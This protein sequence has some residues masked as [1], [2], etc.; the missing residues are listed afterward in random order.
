VLIS[1]LFQLVGVINFRK[2]YSPPLVR[3]LNPTGSD[4]EH[5]I[6]TGWWCKAAVMMDYHR[7]LVRQSDGD[8]YQPAH[9]YEP[10]VILSSPTIH[11]T[12]AITNGFN[13][14]SDDKG[15]GDRSIYSSATSF[16]GHNNAALD[17]VGYEGRRH[18]ICIT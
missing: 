16:I 8:N 7:R 6:T 4:E 18:G 15:V 12:I 2:D 13:D 5:I 10:A 11:I 9:S 14:T 17:L 3:H 1:H